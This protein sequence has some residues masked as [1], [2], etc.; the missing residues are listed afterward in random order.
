MEKKREGRF[1][2]GVVWLFAATLLSK[3]IGL[4]YKIPL[5]RI[6]GV[7][8]MAYFLAAY[9]IY[10]LLFVLSSTGLPNALALLVARARAS[11]QGRQSAHVFRVCALCF[12]GIG[13]A[14]ACVLYWFAA[15]IA[16]RLSMPE[17]E[18]AILAIAPAL[19]FVGW[20]GA[21]RGYFQGKQNMLPCAISESVEALGKLVFGLLFSF[22]LLRRGKGRAELA[23]AAIFGIPVGM[24]IS[25]AVLTLLYLKDRRR[26]RGV[27]AL[28]GTT[29]VLGDLVRLA[30][31]M[32]LS[33]SV[34]SMV[35][36]VDTVLISARLQSVGYAASIANSLYSAYGNL[37]VP[38]YNLVP[39]LLSPL[40]LAI[41]P[42]I[43]AAITKRDR[44]RAG[45]LFFAGVRLVAMIAIPSAMGLCAFA[46]PILSLIYPTENAVA[47]A[48]PL[49]SLLS[50]SVIPACFIALFGAALQA[51]G[52]VRLP[53]LAMALGAVAKLVVE[54][55]LLGVPAVGIHAA[56]ISTLVCNCVVLAIEAVALR[57][58]LA[59][60]SPLLAGAVWRP[61]LC[62]TVSVGGGV[63]LWC[64]LCGRIPERGLLLL[65][66][67]CVVLLFGLLVL[68]TGTLSARELAVLPQGAR[69][70]R[71]LEKCR[72]MPKKG[73]H[74]DDRRKNAGYF[75]KKHLPHRGSAHHC[76]IAP[77]TRRMPMGQGADPSIDAK[78]NDRGDLRGR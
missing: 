54:A 33:A 10:S 34:M 23:A 30:L 25:A 76:G 4:F 62:A 28:G 18:K 1:L 11:G 8:G 7:E 61:L 44:V 56:P 22:L 73:D 3:C 15:P 77:R 63:G 78:R 47:V 20:I 27:R 17:A 66:L 37:A 41:A 26:E 52:R 55:I 45:E 21:V 38:L 71:I 40:S 14:C 72:L 50:L 35:S 43:C 48:A 6:V 36:L 29:H 24:C 69:I 58:V 49:L 31:P 13:G 16:A 42:A 74:N 51:V 39:T 32:T 68:Q 57:R 19:L 2:G 60:F 5:I 67:P 75:G 12:C 53:V 59:G 70:L 9:H 65:V 46:R 64:L